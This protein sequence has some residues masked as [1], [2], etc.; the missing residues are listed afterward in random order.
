MNYTELWALNCPWKHICFCFCFI[1]SLKQNLAPSTFEALYKR[2]NQTIH[3]VVEK[4]NFAALLLITIWNF[5][6]LDQE[7]AVTVNQLL[8]VWGI[9]G[10]FQT[11][12]P[13]SHYKL[14]AFH[15]SS[16]NSSVNY[17]WDF[18]LSTTTTKH[19]KSLCKSDNKLKRKWPFQ[20]FSCDEVFYRSW[21]WLIQKSLLPLFCYRC[22]CIISNHFL[23]DNRRC[24][25]V[26]FYC[27]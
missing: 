14:C 12:N 16:W 19:Q 13:T 7:K 11:R 25:N 24:K 15:S 20:L 6:N 23:K 1:C 21:I 17:H 2:W 4:G 8:T 10:H 22:T 26:T 3:T 9:C 27:P 18:I 5:L